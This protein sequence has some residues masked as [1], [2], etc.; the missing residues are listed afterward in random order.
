VCMNGR[1]VNGYSDWPSILRTTFRTLLSEEGSMIPSTGS[2]IRS[3]EGVES[4]LAVMAASFREE[5]RD[6]F[7]S[8]GASGRMPFGFTAA[9]QLVREF[10]RSLRFRYNSF[11]PASFFR[12]LSSVG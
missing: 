5:G 9:R 10:F 4:A 8:C 7:G 1:R 3:K 12:A 6:Y 11:V 2:S